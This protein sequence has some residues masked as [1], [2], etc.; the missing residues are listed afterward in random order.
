MQNFKVVTSD[1]Q[2]IRFYLYMD[3][4]PATCNEFIKQLPFARTFMHAR[5]S[6]QEFWTDDSPVLN[7]PQENA[8]VFTEPGEIVLG[9]LLPLR[10]KTSKCMG[11]YYGDGKGV[12][13]CNIFGKVFEED[14]ALLK[15]LGERIWKEGAQELFFD[16]L[17]DENTI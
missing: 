17:P 8:S 7:V 15:T 6:G 5:V 12:D 9:P 10:T 1:Q 14:A 13:A 3:N 4:A 16:L 11:I 2:I